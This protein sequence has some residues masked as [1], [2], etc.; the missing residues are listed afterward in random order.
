MLTWLVVITPA[1]VLLALLMVVLLP[2]ELV[3]V[4]ELVVVVLPR[5]VPSGAGSALVFTEI[6]LELTLMVLLAALTLNVFVVL[7]AWLALA[8]VPD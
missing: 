3:T 7:L 8:L 4:T 6:P 5:F 1:R 2:V